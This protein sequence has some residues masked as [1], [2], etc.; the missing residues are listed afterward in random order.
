[1]VKVFRSN[2]WLAEPDTQAHFG[3][4][5]EYVELWTRSLE[6]VMP[7]EVAQRIHADEQP[8]CC[9]MSTLRQSTKN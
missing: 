9:S 4:L 3:T 8:C 6:R 5:I 1:M 2:L 7:F